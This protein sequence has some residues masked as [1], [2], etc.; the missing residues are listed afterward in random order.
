MNEG[1]AA[2]RGRLDVR[3]F[4]RASQNAITGVREGRLM[5]RVTAAPADGAA[6]AL[7]IETI[8]A[9]L[10]VPKRA[11]RIVTGETSRNKSLE[12]DGLDAAAIQARL[13]I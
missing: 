5:V 4:P 10:G 8:A 1:R 2:A 6:N 9:F 13:R 11:V 3:V 12:V 7:V